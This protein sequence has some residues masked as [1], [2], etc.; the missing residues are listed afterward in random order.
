MKTVESLSF[1][2]PKEMVKK[3]QD[4][5]KEEGKTKSRLVRDAIT[6]YIQEKKWRNLQ[7]KTALKARTLGI[8]SEQDVDRLVHQYRRNKTCNR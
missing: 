6:R 7:R 8:S 3:I 2:F 4:M 5:A 1:A